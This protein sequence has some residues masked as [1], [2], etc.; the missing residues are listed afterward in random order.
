[1]DRRKPQLLEVEVE[2][3]LQPTVSRPVCPGVGLPSGAYDQILV[4]FLTIAGFLI[5]D[6]L[7]DERMGL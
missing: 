6:A 1:M 5:W 4:F 2:V 7:S 3:T